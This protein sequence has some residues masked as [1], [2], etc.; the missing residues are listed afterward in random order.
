[1]ALGARRSHIVW[2]VS[3]TSLVTVMCGMAVGLIL[4]LSLRKLLELWMPGNNHSP[5]IFAPVTGL[6][7]AGS[8]LACLIPAVRAAYANPME[9]LRSE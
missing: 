1:M 3:R 9:T 2:T 6:V 8:A 4:N 5:W 7:L